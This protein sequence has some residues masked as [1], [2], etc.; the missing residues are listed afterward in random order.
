MNLT[1]RN[2]MKLDRVFLI[3][4]FEHSIKVDEV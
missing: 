2:E 1:E 3:K 4:F